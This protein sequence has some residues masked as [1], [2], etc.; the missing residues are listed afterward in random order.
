MVKSRARWRPR[1]VALWLCA[2]VGVLVAGLVPAAGWAAPTESRAYTRNPQAA[3]L[4]MSVVAGYDGHYKLGEWFP[5]RV[6][7]TN[8][9]AAV[10]GQVEVDGGD[11]GGGSSA[12]YAYAVSL[13]AP[14]RKTVTLYTYATGYQ[15]DITVR[16]RRGG[17]VLLEQKAT[18]NPLNDAFLLGV[19]SDTP[20]LLNGLSGAMLGNTGRSTQAT[21]AHLAAADVPTLGPALAALDA[22]VVADTD[23][24]KWTPEQR[25]ALAGWVVAGGTLVVAGGVNAGAAAGLADLLPAQM[26]AGGFLGDLSALGAYAG[27]SAPEAGGALASSLRLRTDIPGAVTVVAGAAGPLLAQR[28]LG[29]GAVFALALDPAVAPLRTWD[30][31][32]AFWQTV[33]AGHQTGMSVG[34]GRRTRNNYNSSRYNNNSYYLNNLSPFDIPALQL[35]GVA[36]IGVF[37]LLYVLV[38]GPINWIFLRR[39]RRTEWAWLTIPV[40]IMLFAGLAY[41]LGYGSK[42]NTLR[43][44]TGTLVQTYP[45]APV[46]TVSSFAGLFSP[47]RQAYDLEWDG[48]TTLSEVNEQGSTGRAATLYTG[49]PSAVRDLQIDTWALR[50]FLAETSLPVVAPFSGRLQLSN[51]T[52]SGRITNSGNAPLRDVAVVL[53]NEAQLLGTLAPGAGADVQIATTGSGSGNLEHLMGQLLPGFQ[54]QNYPPPNGAADRLRARKAALL[55]TGILANSDLAVTALGWTDTMPL[56]VRVPGQNPVRD[57]LVLV[58]TQLPLDTAQGRIMLGPA[59][60]PRTLVNANGQAQGGNSDPGN[61]ELSANNVFQYRLPVGITVDQLGLDYDLKPQYGTA[62]FQL[63]AYNWG[64]AGWEVAHD[65]DGKPIG[66]QRIFKG[67]LANPATYVNSDGVLRMRL[68]PGSGDSTYFEINRFD[69]SAEGHR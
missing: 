2:L 49:R 23:T 39:S 55:V 5:V 58:T 42:G 34:A 53:G 44:T 18:I 8:T 36:T 31:A 10:E 66:D 30:R 7:L 68:L 6:G 13:P 59:L 38:V 26:D 14:S 20:D 47:Q 65:T 12:T 54:L 62:T 28:P 9:G 35:P 4:A 50:G 27:G 22:L 48:V 33:F 61:M 60:L 16:L 56:A 24:G 17:T 64:K 69:L 45:G 51:G 1:R 43:L 41:A 3:G 37:L 57:D 25:T 29:Q 46:A 32:T 11:Q 19:V 40:I 63:E 67:N 15:H 21:V 52:V